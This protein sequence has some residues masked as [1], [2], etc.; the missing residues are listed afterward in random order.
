MELV[1]AVASRRLS[2]R[3]LRRL[4]GPPSGRRS[5]PRVESPAAVV[6]LSVEVLSSSPAVVQLGSQVRLAASQGWS[7]RGPR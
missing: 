6:R 3:V 7:G 1:S 2:V 4:L 5:R